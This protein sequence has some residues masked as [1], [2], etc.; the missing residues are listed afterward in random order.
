MTF[1]AVMGKRPTESSH[2][3][4]LERYPEAPSVYY[5]THSPVSYRVPEP[6]NEHLWLP[7]R[8][9]PAFELVID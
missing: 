8:T 2:F 7:K 3:L 4:R 6:G 5:S 1:S 9:Q